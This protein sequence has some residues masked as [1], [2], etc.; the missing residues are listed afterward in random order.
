MTADSGS[1]AADV[2]FLTRLHG[3][4]HDAVPCAKTRCRSRTEEVRGSNPLTSTPSLMTSGNAGHRHV[5][6]PLER[7]PNGWR[8]PNCASSPAWTTPPLLARCS[9]PS[10]DTSGRRTARSAPSA[11]TW[12][13]PGWPRTFW[14]TGQ[15]ARGSDLGRPRKLPRR[16]PAPPSA[17]PAATRYKVLH[18]LYRWLEEE[19][20]LPNPM[21]RMKPP[22]VPEQPVPIV[23]EDG[24]RRL[25][26][27]CAGRGFEA[28]ATPP[29]SC[30][31]WT[32]EPAAP[33]WP[34][35]SLPTST[36][37]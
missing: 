10:S 25:L 29:S 37:T 16:H 3:P 33:S 14:G 27:A 7:P 19:E 17:N 18:V 15:A 13:A 11:T 28:A 21:A 35:C 30:C 1:M 6:G 24:L 8:A 31:C 32:P 22:I 2:A 20:E 36:S 12:K 34:I 5:R 4:Q 26:A 9:V 23:P